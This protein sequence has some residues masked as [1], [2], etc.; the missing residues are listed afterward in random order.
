MFFFGNYP[1]IVCFS[2]P[3]I[4]FPLLSFTLIY[5]FK[6]FLQ[7][8]TSYKGHNK[9]IYAPIILLKSCNSTSFTPAALNTRPT[10][11]NAITKNP[12]SFEN[13]LL[14]PRYT[15]ITTIA[16]STSDCAL[17]K[18]QLY[19]FCPKFILHFSFQIVPFPCQIGCQPVPDITPRFLRLP[20]MI[21]GTSQTIIV[22]IRILLSLNHFLCGSRLLFYQFLMTFA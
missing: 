17:L 2:A 14:N 15:P 5:S 10:A 1:G 19:K 13:S 21:I 12:I 16:I 22:S 7:I 3:F 11:I 18:N 20:Q 6:I 9:I 8:I 4:G